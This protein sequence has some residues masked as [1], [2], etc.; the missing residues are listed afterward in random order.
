MLKLIKLGIFVIFLVGFVSLADEGNAYYTK[1]TGGCLDSRDSECGSYCYYNGPGAVEC[2]I[3]G[4]IK[5][6]GA[7]S[8]SGTSSG[9]QQPSC[10]DN[11]IRNWV[12]CNAPE[13]SCGGKTTGTET[14]VDNCGGTH[15]QP[16]EK[17]GVACPVDTTPQNTGLIKSGEFAWK[18]CGSKTKCVKVQIKDNRNNWQDNSP[19]GCQDV[20]Y[21]NDYRVVCSE[22]PIVTSPIESG[23]ITRSAPVA[24]CRSAIGNWNHIDPI[25]GEGCGRKVSHICPSNTDVVEERECQIKKIDFRITSCNSCD[26]ICG[27]I[28]KDSGVCY[29]GTLPFDAEIKRDFNIA[30]LNLGFGN[31]GCNTGQSCYCYNQGDIPTD[32]VNIVSTGMCTRD[33]R[34]TSPAEGVAQTVTNNVNLGGECFDPQGSQCE[35]GFCN[36]V[37][38]E[39]VD[40]CSSLNANNCESTYGNKCT[41]LPECEG[42]RCASIDFV[43]VNTGASNKMLSLMAENLENPNVEGI[44]RILD[45][46]E[47]TNP[48]I[49]GDFIDSPS[50]I[51]GFA[52]INTRLEGCPDFVIDGVVNF[53]DFFAFADQFGRVVTGNNERF[54]VA[55]D[56]LNIINFDDFFRFADNFGE[57]NI[58]CN[59]SLQ[60]YTTVKTQ[61]GCSNGVCE[62]KFKVKAKY[63]S[64]NTLDKLKISFNGIQAEDK[65]FNMKFIGNPIQ[66]NPPSTGRSVFD[67]TSSAVEDL[68]ELNQESTTLNTLQAP[69]GRSRIEC[70]LQ[71]NP[72]FCCPAGYTTSS[73]GSRCVVVASTTNYCADFNSDSK[74]DFVD[75][76]YITDNFG[77]N[78]GE[79][80]YDAKVDL[81]KD[82]RIGFGDFFIFADEFGAVPNCL[83]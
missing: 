66:S 43:C 38:L 53:D 18:V 65:E 29:S 15:P 60:E 48:L 44:R 50:L 69:S 31:A 37:A 20:V 68:S 19:Y 73:D 51:S 17:L 80:G 56:N 74:V 57:Q 35:S 49:R 21:G 82:G 5:S 32:R 24:S 2:C 36:A 62:F 81:D 67:I 79:V 70:G 8:A 3:G 39:C 83:G 10:T 58:D 13:P 14:A 75:Y 33:E 42:T 1:P 72:G 9:Q 34:T 11:R 59:P 12:G 4:S 22:T 16:C 46:Y 26:S 78:S 30:V 52:T 55:K 63:P 77:V 6:G 61:D 7:C 71:L 47:I 54:D 28:G 40:S 76:F 27:E 25:T 45:E 41:L 64:T 23:G